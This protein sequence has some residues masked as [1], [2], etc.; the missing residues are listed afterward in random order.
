MC[1]IRQRNTASAFQT[2][3]DVAYFTGQRQAYIGE[4]ATSETFEGRGV[5]TALVEACEQ[6]A[7]EQGYTILTLTTGA[8]NARALRFYHSLGLHDEDVNLTKLV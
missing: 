8:A 5:G 6:W 1:Q 2:T 4:L 3:G 7:R